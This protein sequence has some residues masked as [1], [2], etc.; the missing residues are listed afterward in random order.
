MNLKLSFH[1]YDDKR[2]QLFE[3]DYSI[4]SKSIDIIIHLICMILIKKCYSNYFI[5]DL[6]NRHIDKIQ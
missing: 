6:K 1:Y 2:H 3:Y 5:Y 4:T